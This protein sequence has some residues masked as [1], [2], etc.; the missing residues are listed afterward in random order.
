MRVQ[1]LAASLE[2][3]E[4][5]ALWLLSLLFLVEVAVFEVRK[6]KEICLVSLRS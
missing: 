6:S 2:Q 1:R 3:K 4:L 5:R